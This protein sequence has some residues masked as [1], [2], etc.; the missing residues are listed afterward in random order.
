MKAH[1]LFL[2]AVAAMAM[3]GFVGRANADAWPTM[4]VHIIVAYPAGSATDTLARQIGEKL[5]LRWKQAVVIENRPGAAETLATNAVVRAK[6]DGYTL[7]MATEVANETNPFLFSK[8]SYN[9]ETDLTPITRLIDAPFVYVVRTDSPYHTLGQLVDAAKKQ[10]DGVSYGSTGPGASVHLAVNWFA[11]VAGNV[12][13]KHVPYRGLI[14]AVQD[15]LGG[16]I[17]FT[18]APLSLVMPYIKDG[19]L[20]PLASTSAVRLRMLPDV[21]TETE[22]GYRDSVISTMFQLSG[23]AKMPPEL[24]N[25]IATDVSAVLKDPDFQAKNTEPFGY[26]VV[27]GTPAEFVQF[28]AIDREKQ[29]ARVKAAN[30]RLD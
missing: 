20:R 30:V 13:F 5:T 22:L 8:L 16:Q 29:R 18:I 6:S 25:K 9:P 14:L 12:Q 24:T 21:P 4:P 23:P 2:S 17:D 19:K 10:P 26:S 7:L 28:L 3:A 11:T 1:N 15:L 27:A